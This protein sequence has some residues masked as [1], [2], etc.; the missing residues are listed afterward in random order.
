MATENRDIA[1]NRD[2]ILANPWL[3]L[4]AGAALV[5]WSWLWTVVFGE[6][7]SDYR[8][9]IL[10]IGLLLSSIGA[11]L[12][13]NDQDSV[14]LAGGP[15]RL[16]LGGLFGVIAI[17][18]AALFIASLFGPALGLHTGSAFL[19]FIT[20]APLSFFASRR[21]LTTESAQPGVRE[22]AE[23]TALV[24][25]ALAGTC[26]VGSFTLYLGPRLVNEWDTIR[27]VLRVFTA[28]CLYGAALALVATALRRL[29]V[30]LLVVIHF[31]GI[32][33][34]CLSAPPAP[35][36]ANQAWTRLFRPYLEFM[37][38][39]NAYHFYAPEPGPYSYLWF[40]LI[41][42]NPDDGRDYGWWYKVP[43]IAADGRVRHPVALEYQRFLALTE[44]L[45]PQDAPPPPFRPNGE[46]EP[47]FLKRMQVLPR[48]EI[49]V[50]EV[51]PPWPRIPLHPKLSQIQ[52]VHRPTF[53]S[54]HLLKSF[55]RFVAKKYAKHPEEPSWVFKSVK[56]YRAIHHSPPMDVL[57]SG[58]PPDDPQLFHA[59]YL[60]NF[61]SSGDM[62]VDDDPYLYW[63]LPV[64]RKNGLDPASEI[65]D[66]CRLHAGDPNWIRRDG[67]WVPG[68]T[69]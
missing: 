66:Y 25:V 12:R 51:P 63:L 43:H 48:T 21:C 46:T 5:A 56:V 68:P 62:I 67:H 19:V 69:K 52:Q 65:E 47:F 44:S 27:L 23:E 22:V 31:L 3:W 55:A 58:F 38:L 40:R 13:W 37:Y 9:I 17:G 7:A 41:Y 1:L 42:T 45:A 33:S 32:M 18:T 26:L 35:W 57:Q 24:L 30:S 10:F 53:E 4:G 11:R 2:W 20:S 39:V 61:Q 16:A 6:V 36:I 8:I 60:G 29:V 50:G 34:A 14:Y 28:V 54:R 59:Y 64:L 15:V 49:R